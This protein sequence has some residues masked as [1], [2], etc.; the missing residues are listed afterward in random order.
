MSNAAISDAPLYA[1]VLNY[2]A[3][4][5]ARFHMPGH[6]GMASPLKELF[7]DAMR[8]DVTEIPG[9]DS[10]YDAAGPILE[11]ERLAASLF[12]VRETLLS[13]S[14]A[15]LCIQTML[16]LVAGRGQK[17]LCARNLHRSAVNAMALLGLEP[18]WLWPRPQAGFALPGRPD[19]C[20][21]E[22]ELAQD[23]DIAAV[24]LTSP[25]YYGELAD[26]AS[27][28]VVCERYGV[29]LLVDNAHGA[30]LRFC[31]DG[32]LHP[33]RLGASLICDSAHKTLPVLTG[34]AWLHLNAPQFTRDDAKR[35]MALFG[36]TSP[37]YPIMLSL[38]LARA[39]LARSGRKAYGALCGTVQSL[40]ALAAVRGLHPLEG[41][42]CDPARLTLDTANAGVSG[43]TAAQSMQKQGIFPE[44]ADGRHVVLLPTPFNSEEDF[45][46][47]RA[48]LDAFCPEGHPLPL[49]EY[50]PQPPGRVMPLR[51]ALLAPQE[52]VAVEDAAGRVCAASECPCPPGVP[53][54]MPGE[55]IDKTL[56]EDLKNVG[57]FA[58]KV[59]K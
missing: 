42:F 1:A 44:Y 28:A 49:P 48:W 52:T 41:P 13:A 51:E 8:F 54:V 11:A 59:V 20:D 3:Q 26:V 38:D 4:N 53:P 35:A 47:L 19:P 34:G 46:R 25:D 6:K 15:S 27:I 40:R 16:R 23:A 9:T 22:R 2:I 14:G 55:L 32:G 21:V 17:V 39:W 5:P 36:T 56:A 18:V 50:C 30:H 57:V 45:S 43:A 12:G 7:G 33:A 58:V 37:S 24:Y 31:G 29:P 10:L